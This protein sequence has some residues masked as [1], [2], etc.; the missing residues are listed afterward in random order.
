MML[1]QI[2]GDQRFGLFTDLYQLTMMHGYWKRWG[3]KQ[4]EATFSLTFRK[5]P[6]GGNFAILCGTERALEY[7]QRLRFTKDDIEYLQSLEMFSPGFLEYLW[8]FKFTCQVDAMREGT[9]VFPNEPL[10]KVHGPL[11]Q[12]QLVE[13]ALLN[14]VNFETL[15]ATKAHR[16]CQ[17]AGGAP[18]IDMSLRRAQGIDGSLSASRAALVGGCSAT[19]NVLAAKLFGGKATGT[20]AHSWVMVLDEPEAFAL[21]SKMYPKNCILLVDTYDTIEGVK[22][23][24]PWL[25]MA[26][27]ANRTAG[28]ISEATIGIRL[29]SGDMCALSIKARS[30]LNEADLRS[31]RIVASN[32]L[33]E[34]KIAS[35]RANGARIDIWG[36]GTQL[37]TG[38]NQS[39]LGGVY[40]LSRIKDGDAWRY[41]VKLSEDEIKIPIPGD[42]NVRRYYGPTGGDG[43]FSSAWNDVLWEQDRSMPHQDGSMSIRQMSGEGSTGLTSRQFNTVYRDLHTVRLDK[44]ERLEQAGHG[45]PYVPRT[46]PTLSETQAYVK[47]EASH[48]GR[49]IGG[50]TYS[51]DAEVNLFSLRETA[52][53][54]ARKKVPFDKNNPWDCKGAGAVEDS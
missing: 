15:I 40:K 2:Y 31:A 19:S 8:N 12:G 10:L 23:A 25:K 39:A 54:D 29:D 20:H 34:H 28:H 14:M 48:M 53:N 27:L 5:A 6:F 46:P 1:E 11:I 50:D 13:S 42:V 26:R 33:D 4:P 16:I 36:V 32:D 17:A 9:V 37:G 24:I 51:V 52:I 43:S 22:K 44:G 41:P 18:V 7:L 47:L 38:G 35:L 3:D 49:V 30:L 45:G 21:Y